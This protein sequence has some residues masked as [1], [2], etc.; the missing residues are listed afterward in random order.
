MDDSDITAVSIFMC[1]SWSSASEEHITGPSL[2]GFCVFPRGTGNLRC[3]A[4]LLR[5]NGTGCLIVRTHCSATITSNHISARM[6]YVTL[7][8]NTFGM[9]ACCKEYTFSIRFLR[10]E[11]ATN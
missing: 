4:P 7:R 1:S 10:T 6:T 11:A 2:S 3:R 8:E 5:K 9:S